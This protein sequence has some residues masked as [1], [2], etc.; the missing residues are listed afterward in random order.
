MRMVRNI[1]TNRHLTPQTIGSDGNLTEAA[2]SR[3]SSDESVSPGAGARLGDAVG[4]RVASA[5]PWGGGARSSVRPWGACTFRAAVAAELQKWVVH[6][7]SGLSRRAAR[8]PPH[9]THGRAYYKAVHPSETTIDTRHTASYG[10]WQRL[11]E[12]HNAPRRA[13]A[14][15][16]GCTVDGYLKET[17]KPWPGREPISDG[18]ALVAL[19]ELRDAR[20]VAPLDDRA[21]LSAEGGG[22]GDGQKAAEPETFGQ[23]PERWCSLPPPPPHPPPQRGL[24]SRT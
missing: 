12:P 16:A 19:Q 17:A 13:R 4:E 10:L 3:A 5:R 24:S 20:D 22:I 2:C 15:R 6:F 21:H 23:A 14:N 1:L 7:S 9:P 18:G 11:L 8:R